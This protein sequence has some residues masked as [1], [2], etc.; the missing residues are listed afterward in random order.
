MKSAHQRA[1]SHCQCLTRVPIPFPNLSICAVPQTVR[2]SRMKRNISVMATIALVIF[3]TV[4]CANRQPAQ[5][6]ASDTNPAGRTITKE[7][8]NKTGA[9]QTGPALER[10]DPSIQSTGGR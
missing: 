6:T 1:P 3:A 4:G 10:A 7:E 5:P 2:G 8:L 9:Q